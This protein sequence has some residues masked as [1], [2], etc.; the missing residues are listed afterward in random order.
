[1]AE[2]EVTGNVGS[3]P[4]PPYADSLSEIATSLLSVQFNGEPVPITGLFAGHQAN[5]LAIRGHH[6][7]VGLVDIYSS[8][9]EQPFSCVIRSSV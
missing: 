8:D 3:D 4:I 1:M 2:S 5:V 9:Q 6:A 7:L